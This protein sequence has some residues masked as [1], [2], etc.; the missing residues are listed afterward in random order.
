MRLTSTTLLYPTPPGATSAYEYHYYGKATGR[1]KVRVRYLD[2]A[3]DIFDGGT[4]AFSTDNGATWGDE[5]PHGNAVK[6]ERGTLRFFDGLGFVDPVNGLLL[7]L[8]LEGLFTGMSSLE[9]LSQYYLKYRV[10]ADGGRT[11]LVD[12]R[13]IQRGYTPE[14]PCEHVWIGRN[15]MT[16]PANQSMVRTA[17]G[18]LAACISISVP[19]EDGGLYNPGGGFTWLEELILIGRW[20][21]DGRIDWECGPRLAISPEHSTRGL[22]ESTMALMPDGRLLLVMRGSNGG[23]H[24]PEGKI[25]GRKWYSLSSDGGFTWSAPAAWRYHDGELFYSPASMC[26]IVRHSNGNYYWFGNI[27]PENPLANHPR[28]PLLCGQVDPDSCLL[29]RDTLFTVDT[30]RPS[31]PELLQFSNFSVHEDRVTH[32][33]VVDMPRFLPE[34]ERWTG[35]TYEYRIAP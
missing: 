1:E 22:D 18:H 34:G 14:H 23:A 25:P 35:D 6:T 5:R 24:D 7:N 31:D 13:V 27:C 29:R 20:R 16:M 19:G 4:V 15:C 21:E 12:E 9:G 26:V 33:L 8:Y 10:S 2:V 11:S 3:D 32:E 30:R 28:Y 17:Q